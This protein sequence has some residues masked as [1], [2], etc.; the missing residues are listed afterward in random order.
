MAQRRWPWPPCCAAAGAAGR[1]F[2]SLLVHPY[3]VG[4]RQTNHLSAPADA[5]TF[6][7]SNLGFSSHSHFS[8]AFRRAYGRSPS[9]LRR[10]MRRS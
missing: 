2:P 4:R 9:A 7:Q 3:R 8:A 1:S 6:S 5:H 10:A